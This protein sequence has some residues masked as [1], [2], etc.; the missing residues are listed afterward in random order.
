M[1]GVPRQTIGKIGLRIKAWTGFPS[2]PPYF[3]LEP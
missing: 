2:P 3:R 1:L